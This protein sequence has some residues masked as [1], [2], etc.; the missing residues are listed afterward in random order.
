MSK[1][2]LSLTI[3]A[4]ILSVS[5]CTTTQGVP[6]QRP[7]LDLACDA[8][9]VTCSGTCQTLPEWQTTSFDDL[10]LLAPKDREVLEDC[11]AKLQA[12][13]SCLTRGRAAGVVK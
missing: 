4:L 9:P 13:Q 1:P 7:A 3:A 10:I 8:G 5:G 12:C 6:V 11:Q 2:I